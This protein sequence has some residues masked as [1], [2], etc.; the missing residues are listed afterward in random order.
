MDRNTKYNVG[1]QYNRVIDLPLKQENRDLLET[2]LV[3]ATMGGDIHM[4]QFTAGLLSKTDVI[5]DMQKNL[6]TLT[7]VVSNMK[8]NE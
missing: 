7:E 4:A 2:A 3:G 5:A 8:Q 1:R 6:A